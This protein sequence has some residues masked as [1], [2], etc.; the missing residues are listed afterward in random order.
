MLDAHGRGPTTTLALALALV[1]ALLVSLGATAPLAYATHNRATQITWA[2]TGAGREV[3][4]HL[5]FVARRSYYSNPTV[6]STISDP[7]L[8]F[9]DGTSTT[10]AMTVIGVDTARDVIF[11]QAD[12]THTYASSNKV[13]AVFGGCCRLSTSNGHINNPDG[14][15]RTETLVDPA[16]SA[17]PRASINPIVDCR[18]QTVCSFPVPATDPD[19]SRLKWRLAT[20]GEAGSG[21]RQPGAPFAPNDASIDANTGRYTW[22]STGANLNSGGDTYYSTQVIVEKYDAGGTLTATSAVDFFI[23]LT[24]AATELTPPCRDTDN[25]GTS[26]NDGDGLCDNWETTGIDYDDNGSVDLPLYDSNGDGTISP[27]ERAD[28]NVPDV[29]VE[30]DYMKVAGSGPGR[31]ALAAVTNA[32]AQAPTPVR[33][34]I[35][36]D[37]EVPYSRDVNWECSTSCPSGAPTFDDLKDRYFGSNAERGS[38]NAANILGA[39][40]FAFHYA[41]WVN[42]WNGSTFSG[43]GELPGN[44]FLVALGEWNQ[45]TL[46]DGTVDGIRGGTLAQQSGT[47]MH[48]LGHNLGLRHGGGDDVNCKPNYLSVMSYSFQ[49]PAFVPNRPLD[50]SRQKLSSLSEGAL[51]EALGVQGPAGQLT[52]FGNQ[53]TVAAANGPIDWNAN[54]RIDA[55]GV[56]ADVN[57]LA[58]GCGGAGDNLRGYDDWANLDYAFQSSSDFADGVS[59]TLFDQEPEPTYAQLAASS[60]DT[61]GDGVLDLDDNCF[62]VA[63]ADQADQDADG[64][65]DACAAASQ[66]PT[67]PPLPPDPPVQPPGVTP[68]TVKPVPKTTVRVGIRLVRN[69]FRTHKTT[70]I[71]VPRGVDGKIIRDKKLKLRT[72]YWFKNKWRRLPPDDTADSTNLTITWGTLLRG[73]KTKLRVTAF[74]PGYVTVIS[75]PLKLTVPWKK[76]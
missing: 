45:R 1:C 37:D 29:F 5:S 22:N 11:T 60:R 28:P 15:F 74:G 19:G 75:A 47:F 10:P 30:V 49:T 13:T 34:H 20:A 18:P 9:G 58:N 38:T 7:S 48:E 8:E 46:R 57:N 56:A 64:T 73:L 6:G 35:V 17:S 12:V 21:F 53:R 62:N 32:F 23:H 71:I 61:D 43:R 59:S 76:K 27:S 55:G 42:R 4:F 3:S 33:L 72:E 16:G 25:N 24:N 39:K 68:P 70:Y 66:A 40:R 50:Y 14:D 54:G 41:L 36:T 51:S 2:A 67:N 69:G 65:G 52:V 63:N 31:A 44:D 26:D